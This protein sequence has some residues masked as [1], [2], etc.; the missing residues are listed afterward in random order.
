MMALLGL[1]TLTFTAC[2]DD[3]D[4]KDEIKNFWTLT[5]ENKTLYD[6]DTEGVKVTVTLAYAAAQDITLTPMLTGTGAEVFA[7]DPATITIAKGAKTADFYVRATGAAR[8]QNASVLTLN[9]GAVSSLNSGSALTIPVEPSGAAVLTAAQQALAKQWLEKFG[10]NVSPFI[11]ALDAEATVTFNTDDKDVYNNGS[12]TAVYSSKCQVTISDKADA[13][14]IVLHMDNALGLRDFLYKMLLAQSVEDDEFWLANPNNAN[15][16]RAVSYDKTKET[17]GVGLDI[18]IDPQTKAI[19]FTG[20]VYNI[21]YEE[22]QT[23][24]PFE[25]SFS[26]WERQQQLE[27]FTM[28]NGDSP[29]EEVGMAEAISMG[30][31]LNPAHYLVSSDISYDAWETQPSLYT[32]P[33]AAVSNDKMTFRF[34]WDF[35]N[36]SGYEQINVTVRLNK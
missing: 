5:A 22:N 20:D 30:I 36:A 28:S 19:A 12:E 1:L 27:Q 14:H 17:F 13:D 32:E 3:D 6:S 21:T 15:L 35:M 33:T 16:L 34:P 10:F 11:G 31:T 9:I 2:G 24:V 23:G 26:A 7:I 29:A 25:F 18:T 8:L 4:N